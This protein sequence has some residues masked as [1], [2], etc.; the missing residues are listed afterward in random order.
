MSRLYFELAKYALSL[1][2]PIMFM[3]DDDVAE[4]G[5][6]LAVGFVRSSLILSVV[7]LI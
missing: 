3:F 5:V 4:V 2:Y 7:L 6:A 1:A